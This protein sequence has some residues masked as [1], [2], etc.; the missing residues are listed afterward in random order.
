TPVP[1]SADCDAATYALPD[2]HAH[3]LRKA[4]LSRPNNTAASP[5]PFFTWVTRACSASIFPFC[6][7]TRAV[8]LTTCVCNWATSRRA[9]RARRH[10]EAAG[11][12]PVAQGSLQLQP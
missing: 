9:G 5:A 10:V 6:C 2:P 12:L 3:R 7:R 4:G 11:H 1:R 8:E